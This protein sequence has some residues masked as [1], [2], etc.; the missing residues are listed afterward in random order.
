MVFFFSLNNFLAGQVIKAFELLNADPRVKAILVNI[1]GGIM[2]CDT[3]A[4]GV[5][6]AAGKISFALACVSKP[7]SS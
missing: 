3:I 7:G 6:S 1:F 5:V 4:R 2:R